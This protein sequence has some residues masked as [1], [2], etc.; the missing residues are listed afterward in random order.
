MRGN[1][2]YSQCCTVCHQTLARLRLR[3]L[4]ETG[5][6]PVDF[7][8]SYSVS[9]SSNPEFGPEIS[10]L[11]ERTRVHPPAAGFRGPRRRGIRAPRGYDPTPAALCREV[12]AYNPGRRHSLAHLY[13]VRSPQY[14]SW[15]GPGAGSAGHEPAV[16]FPC[17]LGRRAVRRPAVGRA[18]WAE[19]HAGPYKPT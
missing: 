7:G 16:T 11:L 2:I 9:N 8:G 12:Q 5:W 18:G 10:C 15:A 3:K 17:S 6:A 1:Q 13:A 4:D 19:A 14:G